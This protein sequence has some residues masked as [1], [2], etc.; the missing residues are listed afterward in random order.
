M[1]SITSFLECM[2][3]I[4]VISSYLAVNKRKSKWVVFEEKET[5]V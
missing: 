4:K 5:I 1:N 3:V 2:Y